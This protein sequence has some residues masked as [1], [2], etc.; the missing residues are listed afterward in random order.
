MRL[1]SGRYSPGETMQVPLVMMSTA[2]RTRLKYVDPN[3][4]CSWLSRAY[5]ASSS[6]RLGSLISVAVVW[7]PSASGEGGSPTVFRVGSSS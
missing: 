6:T 4:P 2:M 1:R 7:K 3:R 5:A